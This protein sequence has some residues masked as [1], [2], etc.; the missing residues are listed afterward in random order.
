MK[1]WEQP[2]ESVRAMT[3]V[4]VGSTGSWARASSRTLDVVV[5]RARCGVARAQPG[6]QWLAGGVEEGDQGVEPEAVLVVRGGALFVGVGTHQRG[7]E[8]DDVEA[9][10]ETGGPRLS[11]SA[12]PGRG[13]ALQG[14]GIDRLEGPPGRRNRRHVAEQTRLVRQHPQIGDGGGPIGDGHGQIHEHLAPVMAPTGAAWS[15]PSPRRGPAQPEVVGQFAEQ[16]GPGMG[17]H[18]F[19]AGGHHDR[20]VASQ[21]ASSR[22]CPPGLDPVGFAINSF[23][24]HE[25][26][27]ASIRPSCRQNY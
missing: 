24:C 7:V 5:G 14:G 21:Y 1:P 10:V 27:S 20:R 26:V 9:G 13:D 3:S 11:P 15:V 8:V 17:G 4:S 25:G 12:G 19:A 18:A 2:A 16:S 6:G 22:K 23:P